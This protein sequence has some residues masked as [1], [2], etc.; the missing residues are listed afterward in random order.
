MMSGRNPPGKRLPVRGQGWVQGCVM[1][2]V[3]FRVWGGLFFPGDFFLE[4]YLMSIKLVYLENAFIFVIFFYKFSV[5]V[6]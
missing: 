2:R 5:F 1:N 6:I 3:R 4:P